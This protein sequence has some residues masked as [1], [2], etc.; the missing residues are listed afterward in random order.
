MI[1][2]PRENYTTELREKWQAILLKAFNGTSSEFNVQLSES[3][4]ARVLV[5]VRTTPGKIPPY[6]VRELEERLAQAA[7]RWDD[8]LRAALVASLGEARGNALYRQ[9][10]ARCRRAIATMSPRTPRS[11]TSS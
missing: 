8:E 2:A 10:A 1:Y 11:P 5:T 4:L 9:F 7:R 3:A 6:D